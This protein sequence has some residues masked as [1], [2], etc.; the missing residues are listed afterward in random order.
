MILPV[1]H[2][3]LTAVAL[4][5]V[6]EGVLPFLSPSLVRRMMLMVAQTDDRQLRVAGVISMLIGLVLLHLL[7]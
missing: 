5:L 4:M 1:W 2:D 3:L 6:L 7:R